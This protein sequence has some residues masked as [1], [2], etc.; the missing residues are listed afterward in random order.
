MST[1]LHLSALYAE[2]GWSPSGSVPVD[3]TGIEGTSCYCSPEAEEELRKR[4]SALPQKGV[5]WIDTG[6]YHYVSKLRMELVEEPFALALLDNHPDDQAD[7]FGSGLLSC[8]G[9]VQAARDG[10]PL[11]KKDCLNTADIPSPLPVFLSID[12]DVLSPAFARTDWDQGRMTLEELLATVRRIAAEHRV[13]G[14]DVCGGITAA[15]GAT[16][17]DRRINTGTR[18]VLE[19][20]L[21]DLLSI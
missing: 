2:E 20:L 9:W 13:L 10:L 7:A 14:I 5:F 17:E 6:D 11:L 21:P 8:G 12:L 3:L 18:A 1:I 4:L 16:A 19:G 15:K